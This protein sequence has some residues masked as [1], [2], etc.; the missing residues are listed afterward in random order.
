MSTVPFFNR[1]M[2][3]ARAAR[4]LREFQR[5][6]GDPLSF[7]IDIDLVGE[8]VFDLCWDWDVL[9]EQAGERV[10]A[11]LYVADRRA[12]LNQTYKNLFDSKRGMERFTRA[13]EI[14][15]ADLHVKPGMLGQSVDK[16]QVIF[17]RDTGECTER[18]LRSQY[19][20]ERQADWYAAALTMPGDRFMEVVRRQPVKSP[21]DAEQ[22]AEFFGVSYTALNLR[23]RDH[24]LPYFDRD[25]VR[26]VSQKTPM[27]Q[28][29]LFDK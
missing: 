5:R 11:A 4:A 17:H 9:P 24:G 7:P 10:L 15:H 25:G 8:I 18:E 20:R 13:H 12:V 21:A 27:N 14:G 23:L 2:I 22:L 29:S 26:R 16:Q 28:P 1:E 3:E 19:W 6:T